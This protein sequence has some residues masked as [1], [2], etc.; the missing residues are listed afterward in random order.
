M[1][2]VSLSITLFVFWLALSG[3]G[4]ALIVGFGVA[5]SLLVGWIAHRMDVADHEGHPIHVGV[6]ALLYWPWLS[7]QILAS[8]ARVARLILDPRMP[9]AP[10]VENV[11]S[12]QTGTV[13]RVAFANSI[14]LTPGTVAIDIAPGAV[15]VHALERAMIEDLEGGEMDARATRMARGT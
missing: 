6:Q 7:W 9:I 14:T 1:R 8:A 12:S 2:L 4:E 13:G 15:E 5:S 3:H 11:T 10:V